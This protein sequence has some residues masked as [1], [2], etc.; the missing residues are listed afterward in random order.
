MNDFRNQLHEATA[1]PSPPNTDELWALGRRAARRRTALLGTAAFGLILGIGVV[2]AQSGTEDDAGIDVQVEPDTSASSTTTTTPATIPTIEAPEGVRLSVYPVGLDDWD[3]SVRPAEE[4]QS[5]FTQLKL[6]HIETGNLA[7]LG[8]SEYA[9]GE[10]VPSV[11]EWDDRIFF[12]GVDF[13]K[14]VLWRHPSH[15][16]SVTLDGQ[17]DPQTLVESLLATS[18]LSDATAASPAGWEVVLDTRLITDRSLLVVAPPDGDMEFSFVTNFF[19]VPPD[20]SAFFN[21]DVS[22][23]YVTRTVLGHTAYQHQNTVAWADD[24][25]VH[26][27]FAG[28]GVSEGRLDEFLAALRPVTSI[29]TAGTGPS[30]QDHWHIGFAII[31]CGEVWP[32]I[33][34]EFDPDGIHTHGDGLL[35]IH[36][37]NESTTGT[38][39]TLGQFLDAIDYSFGPDAL[40]SEGPSGNWHEL[41]C[42]GQPSETRLIR[43]HAD[44][45]E[46]ATITG[47]VIFSEYFQENGETWVL[48]RAP[49]GTDNA[50]LE[51]PAEVREALSIQWPPPSAFD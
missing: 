13:R 10:E 2:V 12:D 36:P 43:G 33:L 8:V 27:V 40:L 31:E 46:T 49:I 41:D 29:A 23:P 22:P 21:L 28:S 35:H 16:G 38:G 11:V 39:A 44:R 4:L 19:D 37:F 5:D 50:G 20:A 15:R 18:L 32:T 25:A 47:A 34:N 30:L 24:N 45:S 14:G 6:R 1:T 9:E 17:H 48:A 7:N 51:I 3:I 26:L 42:D